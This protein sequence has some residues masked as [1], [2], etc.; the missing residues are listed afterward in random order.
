M[1]QPRAHVSLNGKIFA[2]LQDRADADGRSMASIVEELVADV[3]VI[4]TVAVEVSPGLH[5]RIAA[6]ARWQDVPISSLFDS[7]L[8]AAMEAS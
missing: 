2:A 3:P 6:A 4:D 5:R 7:L 8:V 1:R